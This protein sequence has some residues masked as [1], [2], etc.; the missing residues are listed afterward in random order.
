MLEAWPVAIAGFTHCP[1]EIGM[2]SD[3][4]TQP[5]R[6]AIVYAPPCRRPRAHAAEATDLLTLADAAPRIGV[7]VETLLAWSREGL[8]ALVARHEAPHVP[9]SEVER[10][11]RTLGFT[12]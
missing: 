12:D 9:I 1:V 2:R 6:T 10:V 4:L 11:R 7:Q 5:S 3:Q 8:L